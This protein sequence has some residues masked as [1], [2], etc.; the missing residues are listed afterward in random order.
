[1]PSCTRAP[2]ESFTKM[3]GL[4]VFRESFIIVDNFGAVHFAGRS[5]GYREILRGQVDQ[6]AVNGRAPGDDAVSRNIFVSH[7]KQGGPMLG[8]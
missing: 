1:M 5:A 8:E 2:P 4:P 6:T 3:N 7:A